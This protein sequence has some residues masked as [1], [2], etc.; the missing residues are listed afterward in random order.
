M[1]A[2]IHLLFHDNTADKV[3]I[4]KLPHRITLL[5]SNEESEFVDF[6]HNKLKNQGIVMNDYDIKDQWDLVKI[7]L[8]DSNVI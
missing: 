2:R 1:K 3:V 5:N 7:E 6:C 4:V 8:L